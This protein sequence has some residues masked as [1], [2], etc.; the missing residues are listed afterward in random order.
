MWIIDDQIEN[1][2]KSFKK[3]SNIIH[4]YICM[5]SNKSIV[6]VGCMMNHNAKRIM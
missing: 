4:T 6:C 5:Y 3:C 2:P 1:L